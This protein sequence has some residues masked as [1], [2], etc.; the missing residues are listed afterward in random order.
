VSDLPE[1]FHDTA[2]GA[3][4]STWKVAPLGNAAEI[5]LG[6]T[7]RRKDVDKYWTD[8]VIPWVTISDLNNSIVYETEEGVSR[9]ALEEVFNEL[10]VPKGSLL[11]SFKLTIG[12][13]GILGIDAVHNDLDFIH[14]KSV[15][16]NTIQEVAASGS[17]T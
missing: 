6:R 15:G 17:V 12:K 11:L 2:L 1:G 9:K 13:V 14:F 7:P 5:D 3:L 16:Q 8:G 4:P 10:L